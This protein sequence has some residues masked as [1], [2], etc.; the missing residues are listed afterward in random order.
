MFLY[1]ASYSIFDLIFNILD[2]VTLL[3]KESEGLSTMTIAEIRKG[4]GERIIIETTEFKGHK[5]IDCRLYYK[6]T[7]ERWVPS[8]KGI[9]LSY[10]VLD[11]FIKALHRAR[12]VYR[13]ES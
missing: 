1:C 8:K 2:I 3:N 5:Y 6:D 9:T 11:D 7:H 10:D 4:A 13:E 12:I